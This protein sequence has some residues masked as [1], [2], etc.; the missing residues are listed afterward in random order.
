MGHII[1]TPAGAFRANWR[2]PSGKQR[3]KTFPTKKEARAHLAKVE[4]DLARGSYVDA[5]AGRVL[6]KDHAALWA[7][8]RNL[9]RT[10]AERTASVLR[11]HLLPKWSAW[12]LAKIDHMSVQAWVGDLGRELAPRTVAKVFGTMTMIMRAAV[13]GR[14]IPFNPCEDVELPRPA[15]A[16]STS[17]IISREDFF[18]KLLP[19]V[20]KEHRPLVA[21]AAMA[22]LRWGECA[23]LTWDAVNL[24]VPELH[25]ART[26]VE[27]NGRLEVTPYPKSRA[28]KRTI[29]LPLALTSLLRA[30]KIRSAPNPGGLVFAVSTGSAWR[31]ANFRRQVWAPAVEASGIPPAMRFHDLRHC[32]A[33]WLVSDGVPI[34]EVQR[35]LGHEQASTTLDRYTHARAATT[36]AF[37][38]CSRCLL[39]FC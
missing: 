29:P 18:A 25:V 28:G 4:L 15:S 37:E 34:N 12:P 22:G 11:A 6:F 24:G 19:A 14:M 33:T 8:G 17:V 23:G 7:A 5:R 35:L 20:P 27:V 31:R 10:S 36:T 1:S 38:R 21:T 13:R 2:D 16:K 32:Y 26:V 3:S 39:I 9:E 30:H